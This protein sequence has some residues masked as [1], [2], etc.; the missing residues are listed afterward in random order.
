[1]ILF[2]LYMVKDYLGLLFFSYILDPQLPIDIVI[3]LITSCLIGISGVILG[4]C[5]FFK[6]SILENIVI[7]IN[8]ACTIICIITIYSTKDRIFELSIENTMELI[9]MLIAPTIGFFK[10]IVSIKQNNI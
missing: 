2:M 7:L 6:K 5:I 8:I 10:I 3:V 4:V 1:M 9:Y